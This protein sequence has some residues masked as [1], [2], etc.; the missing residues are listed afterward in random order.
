MGQKLTLYT[1]SWKLHQC[2]CIQFS[3]N[4]DS[5]SRNGNN[6][7]SGKV[8]QWDLLQQNRECPVLGLH[9]VYPGLLLSERGPHRAHRAM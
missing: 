9:A 6:K 2:C 7:Q 5:S 3:H 8:S 1:V 4:A